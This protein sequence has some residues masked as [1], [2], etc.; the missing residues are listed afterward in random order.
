IMYAAKTV[1]VGSGR[2]RFWSDGRGQ[3]AAAT[4]E[5]MKNRIAANQSVAVLPEGVMLN[6]LARRPASTPYTFFT[7]FD[8]L[9][10]REER[11]LEAFRQHPP[12]FVLLVH[13]DMSEFGFAYFGRDYARELFHW[14]T[15][16]YT[17]VSLAGG[18]PF[19]D[20]GFGI[21]LLEHKMDS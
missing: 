19:Q 18:V 10:F 5:E 7:P 6:Y 11:V 1:P 16:H 9:V 4:L 13:I 21:L 12:D 15:E 8:M 20:Q 17:P 2:D 14:V 3:F